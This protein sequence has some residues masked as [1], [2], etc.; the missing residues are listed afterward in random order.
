MINT[1]VEQKINTIKNGIGN[2]NTLMIRNL[3]LGIENPVEAVLIYIN[4]I[5]D[6][7]IINDNILNPLMLHIQE[8]LS[9]NQNLSDYLCKKYITLSFSEIQPDINKV[10]Q[11]IK[12]GKAVLIIGNDD[13]FIISD[14]TGGEFRG[15]KEPEME[16]AIRGAREG[17][18]ENLETNISI[19][20]RRLRDKNLSIENFTLG[21]RGQM[22]TALIY[23]E[24]IVDKTLVEE[25]KKR[26]DAID[27]DIISAT[28]SLEQVIENH[29]NTL[30]PQ[31]R[32]TERPDIVVANLLEGRIAITLEGSPYVI[33]LPAMFLDFFQTVED[34]Y[35][36]PI[37][38][39]AGRLLRI[40]AVFIVIT[41]PSI[42][43]SFVKFNA[44]L[45]PIQFIEPII[46]SRKGLA[47]SPIMEIL[48]MEIVVEFLREGGLRLPTKIGQTV[49]VVG[50]IIVGDAALQA[51][52]VSPATLLVV[53]IATIASFLI[54]NYQMSLAIRFMRVPMLI[55]TN[56]FGV[57]GITIIWFIIT[58]HLCSM[59]SFGVPYFNFTKGD[60]KDSFIRSYLWMMNKRPENVSNND[61]IRQTD[62]RKKFRR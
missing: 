61:P 17:F 55:I 53:G 14:T 27:M 18:V 13:N 47:L 22:D 60:F 59:D 57:F 29:T 35:E 36:R 10:I 34:Y 51:R 3:Y 56:T 43:L 23:I 52:F 20:R 9:K 50:G 41:L 11:S 12:R 46:Q 4:G 42:Y 44:E 45:L 31:T 5:V 40:F 21:K 15:I 62:F 28:A 26:L 8:D 2:I 48:A 32:G 54:S 16:T 38:G 49:S 37:V 7:K 19:I 1:A 24:D 25:I 6:K 58:V 33:L 30:L 39:S